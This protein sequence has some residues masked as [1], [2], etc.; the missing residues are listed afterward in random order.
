M[1]TLNENDKQL[2]TRHVK[3]SNT[4]VWMKPRTDER[5]YEA[6]ES[7]LSESFREKLQSKR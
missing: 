1:T 6:G 7:M 3:F 4:E 2:R 5:L